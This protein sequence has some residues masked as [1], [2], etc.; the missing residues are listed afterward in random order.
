VG[1]SKYRHPAYGDL[2]A[3]IAAV[4]QQNNEARGR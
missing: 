3:E 4:R 2:V 1:A